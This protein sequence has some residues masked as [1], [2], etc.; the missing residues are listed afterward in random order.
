MWPTL[1][2]RI[3]PRE[4]SGARARSRAVCLF[5]FDPFHENTCDA[6]PAGR[7][8]QWHNRKHL[9]PRTLA[10]CSATLPLASRALWH[11]GTSFMC[12][13]KVNGSCRDAG[14]T[15]NP[16]TIEGHDLGR[17]ARE[18]AL[19]TRSVRLHAD[20]RR[21][22]MGQ[23]GTCRGRSNMLKPDEHDARDVVRHHGPHF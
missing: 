17:L 3:Y 10:T 8:H 14:V 19:R 12:I 11:R 9:N 15:P 5:S 20:E 13:H 7:T 1:P 18:L 23:P 6:G 21:E 22:H 4:A 16:D 2:Q